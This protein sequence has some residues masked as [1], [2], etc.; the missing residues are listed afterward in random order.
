MSEV[1]LVRRNTYAITTTAS[2]R[3][4]FEDRAELAASL[5]PKGCASG[6]QLTPRRPAFYIRGLRFIAGPYGGTGRRV[7][8]KIGFRKEC[9]FD[10]G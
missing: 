2:T 7:R 1:H 3:R 8:L 10:S 9:W 4:G 5:G 6:A